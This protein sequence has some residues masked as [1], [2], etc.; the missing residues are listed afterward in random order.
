MKKRITAFL[1]RRQEDSV[2]PIRVGVHQ[3]DL[4]VPLS[5]RRYYDALQKSLMAL[6][7]DLIPYTDALAPV[8]P[9]WDLCWDPFCG[10]PMGPVWPRDA[11]NSLPKVITFHGGAPWTL[12]L[13]E[14]WGST[15][16]AGAQ[17]QQALFLHRKAHWREVAPTLCGVITPSR[18]GATEFAQHIAAPR[19]RIRSCPHGV[20]TRVFTPRGRFRSDVGFLHVSSPQPKKNIERVIAAYLQLED[21]GVPLTLIVPGWE[22]T[23]EGDPRIH[24][25]TEAL[26]ADALASYYRGATALI[27]PSLHETFGLPVAEAM[28]CGCP[29]LSALGSALEELYAGAALLVDPRSVTEI[30]R[31]MQVLLLNEE[32]RVSLRSRG[33]ERAS[34]LTWEHSAQ[35]HLAHFQSLLSPIR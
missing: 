34:H 30:S 14:F 8:E 26:S 4:P 23:E 7:V 10:W 29:V 25:V 12:D 3:P 21:P 15:E 11:T 28:A 24:I 19:A 22:R 13:E 33:L 1:R 16:G 6:S 17:A 31:G 2:S 32:Q 20:D 5:L 35:C 9:D 18:F 27:F